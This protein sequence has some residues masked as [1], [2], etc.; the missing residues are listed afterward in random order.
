MDEAASICTGAD[1]KQAIVSLVEARNSF[2][3][4]R[5]YILYLSGSSA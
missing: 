5:L 1:I 3:V 2:E 4:G